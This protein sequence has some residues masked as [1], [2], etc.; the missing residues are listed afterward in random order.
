MQHAFERAQDMAADGD[1]DG[2][3]AQ[4]AGFQMLCGRI[5]GTYAGF[6]ASGPAVEHIATGGARYA[7]QD[8]PR[9]LAFLEV[10][11]LTARR[12]SFL[13]ESSPEP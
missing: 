5:S 6:N 1:A 10:S 13:Q 11:A 4:Q 12:K 9:N 7:L 2:A 3:D 8:V